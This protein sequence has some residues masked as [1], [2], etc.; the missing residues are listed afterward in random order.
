MRIHHRVLLLTTLSVLDG[1]AQRASPTALRFMAD[2]RATTGQ[3]PGY[4]DSRQLHGESARRRGRE[5]GRL[6]FNC[7]SVISA[8]IALSSEIMLLTDVD[9]TIDG[10]KKITIDGEG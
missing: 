2:K 9:T 7:G 8:T 3:K 5:R 1:V 10:G 6:R 4:W